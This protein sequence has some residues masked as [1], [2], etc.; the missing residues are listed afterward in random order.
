[1]NVL[2]TVVLIVAIILSG[3]NFFANFSP[4]FVEL[5]NNL[6]VNYFMDKTTYNTGEMSAAD[7]DR[8]NS[9]PRMYF[10]S[11]LRD[12]QTSHSG[13]LARL[14]KQIDEQDNKIIR[15]EMAKAQR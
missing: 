8:I 5:T 13:E 2:S 1:M 15:M 12:L 14:H 10:Q 7:F 11:Q 6:S 4:P 3:A 9:Y